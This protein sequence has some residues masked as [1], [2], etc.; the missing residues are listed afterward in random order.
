MPLAARIWPLA[1]A[2][3]YKASRVTRFPGVMIL[4]SKNG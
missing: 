3:P 4:V 1:S 2:T